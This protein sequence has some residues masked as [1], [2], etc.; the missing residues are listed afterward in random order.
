LVT[1]TTVYPANTV[2]RLEITFP[3]GIVRQG[4]GA[5]IDKKHVLT[6]AHNL[7]RPDLGG[8]AKRIVV[9][10][11]ERLENVTDGAILTPYGQA[12]KTKI[13]IDPGWFV[14]NN[15]NYDYDLGV[16]TLD[17][18][19]PNALGFAALKEGS[20][21]TNLGMNT[22]GYPGNASVFGFQMYSA[23]GRLQEGDWSA[24]QLWFNNIDTSQGQSGAPI[25]VDTSA[26]NE[27]YVVAII[28]HEDGSFNYATRITP[29]QDA[30][31]KKWLQE[32]K[33]PKR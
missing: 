19:F 31:I 25:I 10:P 1:N 26:H 27:R 21:L 16:I 33:A 29:A 12:L 5:L 22:A 18:K 13:R 17:K 14:N 2:C 24:S 3:D 4:S 8:Y 30:L 6:V 32:D 20:D 9:I 11:G 15:F 23:F 28:S 7:Y